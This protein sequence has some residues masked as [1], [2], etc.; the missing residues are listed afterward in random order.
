MKFFVPAAKDDAYA[1]ELYSAV[2]NFAEE[3]TRWKVTPRR[4][5][6]IRYRHDSR[7]YD[8]RVGEIEPRSGE[9][10]VAILESQCV[11][12]CTPNHGVIRGMPILVGAGEHSEIED[13]EVQELAR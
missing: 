12:I 7:S 11:L 4:I 2:V 3:T 6:H 10:V 8:A 5:Y 9:P 13:F 1:E